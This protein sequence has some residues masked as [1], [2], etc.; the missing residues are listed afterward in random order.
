LEKVQKNFLSFNYCGESL[1]L[2]KFYVLQK[3]K[4]FNKIYAHALF[5]NSSSLLELAIMWLKT[6]EQVMVFCVALLSIFAFCADC[7]LLKSTVAGAWMVFTLVI[8]KQA[9]TA[10]DR[11][12]KAEHQIRKA[13]HAIREKEKLLRETEGRLQDAQD[14]LRNAED[15]LRE[16]RKLCLQTNADHKNMAIA[17][18]GSKKDTSIAGAGI[19]FVGQ[20]DAVMVSARANLLGL[21]VSTGFGARARPDGLDIGLGLNFNLNI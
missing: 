16:T 14:R 19:K 10:S 11:L 7:S 4:I 2:V 21:G 15:R 17:L 3:S 18:F 9:R 12:R 1:S 8:V 13:E 6:L 5:Q 20:R